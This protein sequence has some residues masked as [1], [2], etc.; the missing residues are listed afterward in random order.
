M[1][2]AGRK[3]E[4]EEA[5]T[6]DICLSDLQTD[7]TLSPGAIPSLSLSESTLESHHGGLY[8][9]PRQAYAEINAKGV[10]PDPKDDMGREPEGVRSDFP[11]E[12]GGLPL[13]Q[14]DLAPPQS[15]T[16]WTSC[17]LEEAYPDV[18]ENLRI[19][20]QCA[21]PPTRQQD[22]LGIGGVSANQTP[23]FPLLSIAKEMEH[24]PGLIQE[25]IGYQPPS[26]SVP[27]RPTAPV[28]PYTQ[29]H[30]P[31][32]SNQTFLQHQVPLEFNIPLPHHTQQPPTFT[33]PQT[34]HFPL[35]NVPGHL[36][37]TT[38][39]HTPLYPPPDFQLPHVPLIPFQ[40]LATPP[41]QPIGVAAHHTAQPTPIQPPSLLKLDDP[42]SK[43]REEGF[44]LL[45]IDPVG[46]SG[47]VSGGVAAVG[48]NKADQV[49]RAEQTTP[50]RR[51]TPVKTVLEAVD[52]PSEPV[53]MG[54]TRSKHG[55]ASSP[56]SRVGEGSTVPGMRGDDA[57]SVEGWE[58]S[59]ESGKS[60]E[61][62]QSKRQVQEESVSLTVRTRQT[63]SPAALSP[64]TDENEGTTGR[65]L[66]PPPESAVGRSA[67][68]KTKP[69]IFSKQR[70]SLQS[71]TFPDELPPLESLEMRRL[72]LQGVGV[73]QRHHS[74][75]AVT[76]SEKVERSTSPA[77]VV[78]SVK[79]DKS[80]S[81]V[82]LVATPP[83]AVSPPMQTTKIVAMPPSA[84]PPTQTTIQLAL[85]VDDVQMTPPPYPPP[86]P[87]HPL[88]LLP[89]LS[90]PQLISQNIQVE[91]LSET[92]QLESREE[93]GSGGPDKVRSITEHVETSLELSI[94]PIESRPHPQL[95]S[96]DESTS[97]AV[98][99][100]SLGME[101]ET[102]VEHTAVP[103]FDTAMQVGFEVTPPVNLPFCE[104][105]V[106]Q[107]LPR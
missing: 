98:L 6:S 106:E 89:P 17:S 43:M 90:P 26:A 68:Y 9:P 2:A 70:L 25:P 87:P 88:P 37:P 47:G 76:P 100:P 14:M 67:G 54:G 107:D 50:D 71:P 34:P 24:L 28:P 10:R 57:T 92:R 56:G 19:F 8:M 84:T 38:T 81:P 65:A 13:L 101:L 85:R 75:I 102:A 41:I 72:H 30:P 53:Q 97:S 55:V 78:P 48:G 80:T 69:S 99:E 46:V 27:P 49:K 36:P 93:V 58:V 51:F 91:I 63:R 44:R 35:L 104:D 64:V 60:R 83:I 86:Q 16:D 21:T 31:H 42:L 12:F 66:S 77:R 39:Y 33:Y 105:A 62:A 103:A 15:R 79:V 52:F 4:R 96:L 45:S 18:M 7:T 40:P 94:G 74:D 82:G 1:L 5:S 59:T 73:A 29:P 11:P 32:Y 23:A 61:V 95:P 3:W 22:V 20:D